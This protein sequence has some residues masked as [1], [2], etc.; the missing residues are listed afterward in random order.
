[1]CMGVF[2]WD[3]FMRDDL[4]D[5]MAMCSRRNFLKAVEDLHTQNYSS[6]SP[7][8]VHVLLCL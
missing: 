3:V 6:V 2:V 8:E 1:M 5:L 4:F 7:M